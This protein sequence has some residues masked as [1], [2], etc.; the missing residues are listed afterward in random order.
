MYSPRASLTRKLCR[1]TLPNA[2][3]GHFHKLFKFSLPYVSLL[4]PHLGITANGIAVFFSSLHYGMLLIACLRRVVL[5]MGAGENMT[6]VSKDTV[7]ARTEADL[8][9]QS[10]SDIKA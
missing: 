10:V 7:P 2:W 6:R 4:F 9:R 5:S 8:R 3:L 1:K